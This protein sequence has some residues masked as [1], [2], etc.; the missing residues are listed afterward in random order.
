MENMSLNFVR[1]ISRLKGYIKKSKQ[2]R[3]KIS[4]NLFTTGKNKI[5][6]FHD[7]WF[8]L[9]RNIN[10][11]ICNNS[12]SVFEAILQLLKRKWECAQVRGP[13]NSKKNH[14]I[15][16]FNPSTITQGIKRRRENAEESV[17]F[18]RIWKKIFQ[19]KLTIFLN[20]MF[21]VYLEIC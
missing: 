16:L 8:T 1:N 4:N 10:R 5:W 6:D 18:A 17:F 20:K 15:T 3:G 9:S 13:H 12:H 21:V 2:N 14:I 7:A 19:E 11:V